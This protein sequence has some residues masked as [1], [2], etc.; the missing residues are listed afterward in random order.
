MPWY[1]RITV[2]AG[3]WVICVFFPVSSFM[4]ATHGGGLSNDL[5][6]WLLIALCAGVPLSGLTMLAFG[7]REEV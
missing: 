2:G 4:A 6:G 3:L 5:Q 7:P 1:L